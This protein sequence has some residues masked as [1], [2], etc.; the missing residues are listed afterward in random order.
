MTA[1]DTSPTGSLRSVTPS[2]SG[3][4]SRPPPPPKPSHLSSAFTGTCN[5]IALRHYIQTHTT[6]GSITTHSPSTATISRARLGHG[7]D[8]SSADHFV[9]AFDTSSDDGDDS[10]IHSMT[11]PS[12]RGRPYTAPSVSRLFDAGSDLPESGNGTTRLVRNEPIA[13]DGCGPSRVSDLRGM[14]EAAM[15]TA[16]T[17]IALSRQN[18]GLAAQHTG[19]RAKPRISNQVRMLQAQIT[20]DRFNGLAGAFNVAETRSSI[21]IETPRTR[22]S[23][24]RDVTD[25]SEDDSVYRTATSDLLGDAL[26]MDAVVI[27]PSSNTDTIKA[28]SSSGS[29]S[30][31]DGRVSR[32]EM[33]TSTLQ[34]FLGRHQ[35]RLG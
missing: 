10:E 11:R 17:P 24:R 30:S 35:R 14:F 15:P 9:D 8:S 5:S 22:R 18:T 31:A 32:T 13:I 27:P 3:T 12:G 29:F 20:G 23:H 28:S 25:Q 34:P 19:N 4:M 1:K 21:V 16:S 26:K 33:P 2:R 6:G 7:Y